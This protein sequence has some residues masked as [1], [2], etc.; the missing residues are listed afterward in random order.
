MC[1]FGFGFSR[2]LLD[3]PQQLTLGL[4]EVDMHWSLLASAKTGFVFFGSW[5][6]M[7]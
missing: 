2:S 6:L 7:V 3:L 4:V 1:V 5:R